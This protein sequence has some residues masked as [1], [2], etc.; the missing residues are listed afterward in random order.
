MLTLCRGVVVYDLFGK[1]STDIKA[2]CVLFGHFS[3]I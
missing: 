1:V 3:A 2:R